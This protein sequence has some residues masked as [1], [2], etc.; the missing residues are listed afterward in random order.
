MQIT[1]LEVVNACLASMG[2]DPVNS[3]DTNN[4]FISAAL[5]AMQHAIPSELAFG[6]YFNS[7][8]VR[9]NPTV[10]GDVFAPADT[11]GLV[12]NVNPPWLSLRG[13]RLYNNHTGQVFKT[14]R[15]IEVALIRNLSLE[16]LPF[17][18]ARMVKAATV[19]YFQKSY[20]GDERKIKDADDEYSESR[21]FLMCEHIRAVRSN[22]LYQGA[23][24]HRISRHLLIQS[25]DGL[26]GGVRG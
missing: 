9:L 18:A 21:A 13:R 10:E 5:N 16:D 23:T 25:S 11:L 8:L 4:I 7:E 14:S 12:A 1:P 22:M 15:P 3:L 17:H 6:W 24:A 20:D 2:E 26:N 19:R